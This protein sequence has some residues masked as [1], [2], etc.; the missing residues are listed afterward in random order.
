MQMLGSWDVVSDK[1]CVT[2]NA[3]RVDG[4]AFSQ[5]IGLLKYCLAGSFLMGLERSRMACR[6][7]GQHPERD[8]VHPAGPTESRRK[9]E[10]RGS[11]RR[12]LYR[13]VHGA[14]QRRSSAGQGVDDEVR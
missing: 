4:L 2:V 10:K 7:H 3:S 14:M 11:F 9:R 5:D 8:G 1:G 12:T 13:P 6:K